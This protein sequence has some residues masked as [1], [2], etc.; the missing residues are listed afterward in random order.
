[1]HLECIVANTEWE[2]L[3]DVESG[4]PIVEHRRKKNILLVFVK[5]SEIHFN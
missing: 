3:S 4:W 1:M 2:R 5:Q